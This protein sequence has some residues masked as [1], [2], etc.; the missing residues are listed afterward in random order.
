MQNTINSKRLLL[1]ATILIFTT[2]PFLG[3]TDFNTKGE[4]REAIVAYTMT[5]SGNW[6]LPTNNGGEMAYKPPMFHWGIAVASSIIGEV[7]EWTSRFPSAIACIG[8]IIWFYCFFSRRGDEK[9][10]FVA[11]LILFTTFEVHRAA[12][13]C[14]VDMVLTFFIV[15]ALLS[16]AS[17]TEK[18]KRGIPWIAILMMSCGTLTKGPVAIILPCA[19][20]GLFLLI[21]GEN[22]FKLAAQFVAIALGALLIPATWYYAAYQ[23][24][25]EEFLELVAEENIGR[26]LGKMTYESHENPWWYN[27]EMIVLGIIPW[28][29]LILIS[30]K[31]S[32]FTIEKNDSTWM[33]WIKGKLAEAKDK[34][35]S[36]NP[37]ERFAFL[38]AVVVFVFYCIPKSKRGV[39]LLP[40]YPFLCWFIAKYIV[41]K[42]QE[43]IKIVR[44]FGHFITGICVVAAI[45]H[46]IGWNID[47]LKAIY[48][49][50]TVT[51][52]TKLLFI[53]SFV[54]AFFWW[55]KKRYKCENTL[56]WTA[57]GVVI[58]F[59]SLDSTYQPAA[60]NVKSDKYIAEKLKSMDG[61][62]HIT[63]FV[64]DDMM[65]F[66]TI[67]YYMNDRV[68][69]WNDESENN[70]LLVIGEKDAVEFIK[71]HEA[72]NFN[73]EYT[74]EKKSCDVK[75]QHVQVYRFSKISEE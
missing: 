56:M 1:L 33:A 4:P 22:I 13:A 66:F 45:A 59:F 46:C 42:A 15:G 64:D 58:L 16:F 63:S 27:I 17:W 32:Y 40:V 24:G 39:Y 49:P 69:V 62:E 3:I 44:A 21:K 6:I 43:N 61:N 53:A 10:A 70:G 9:T 68:G 55:G 37:Y 48:D 73:L 35:M 20:T 29:F 47:S 41:W 30:L 75:R 18:E 7:N 31:K 50:Q 36:A 57:A 38:A 28:L 52:W 72:Y 14:R 26:F 8:M 54:Y 2:L 65:H 74:S 34:I 51:Y 12:F 67:N 5:E 60:L 19:T 11:S 71:G 25:G 23:Q